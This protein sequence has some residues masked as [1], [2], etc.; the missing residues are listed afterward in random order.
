MTEVTEGVGRAERSAARPSGTGGSARRR[1][2]RLCMLTILALLASAGC[3]ASRAY[4]SGM[5]AQRAEQHEDAIGYLQEAL[6]HDPGDPKYSAALASAIAQRAEALIARGEELERSEQLAAAYQAYAQAVRTDPFNDHGLLKRQIAAIRLRAMEEPLEAVAGGGAPAGGRAGAVL[7]EERR[8]ASPPAPSVPTTAA[9]SVQNVLPARAAVAF[10][11][12]KIQT[13]AGE[14]FSVR[15]IVAA[16]VWP[17]YGSFD[18]IY[19]DRVLAIASAEP[20]ATA[21]PY[22]VRQS[23]PGRLSFRFHPEEHFDGV[24]CLLSIVAMSPERAELT[25]VVRADHGDR[26]WYGGGPSSMARARPRNGATSIQDSTWQEMT[27]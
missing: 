6:K 8:C 4:N 22:S 12:R 3:A 19:D 20:G 15:V 24:A 11:P 2:I 7:A 5:R 23:A 14:E 27:R 1:R 9:P 21:G 10:D 18:V 13:A 17:S 25:A 26:A 16:R